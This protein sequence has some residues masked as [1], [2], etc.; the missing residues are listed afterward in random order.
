M[1]ILILMVAA[2]VGAEPSAP[3][4]PPSAPVIE[5]PVWVRRPS[6]VQATGLYPV[7]AFRLEVE[8]WVVMACDVR[9][10]GTLTTCEIIEETPLSYGFGQ[11][12]LKLSGLF[13]MEPRTP[14][15]RSVAGAKV[16]LRLQF[17]MPD[18]WPP[19]T[20]P[21]LD[22]TAQPARNEADG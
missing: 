3:V 5:N 9:A 22:H 19:K 12:A 21:P 1:S 14:D 13:Q 18:P 16:R 6:A 15:G 2:V 4:E 10:D 20:P 7:D 11:A 17:N 8:G